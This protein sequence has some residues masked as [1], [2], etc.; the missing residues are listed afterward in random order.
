MVN[1]WARDRANWFYLSF[2]I[3][4]LAIVLLGFSTTY[5]IPMAWRSFSAPPI[6]HLHGAA[7]LAWVTIVIVQA[8][9]VSR[10]RT[11]I[12]RRF[13][14]S[15]L[16]LALLVWVSGIYTSVWA[17][18][19]DLADQGTAATSSLAGSAIGLS[20]YLGLVIAAVM[21]RRRPDWHKR[22]I[23]LATIQLLWPAFFRLRHLMPMIPNP[24]IWLALVLAY[25]P[26][27][28]FALRDRLV[29]GRIHPVW[30]FV[31]PALILEQSIEF[32]MFDRGA[33]RTLGQW[34]YSL[35]S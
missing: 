15:A 12:H 34:I 27:V 26:V 20:L 1:V 11:P 5:I 35:L 33:L 9:L 4:A 31:A 13:G 29:C 7:A 2:G 21:L 24:E 14:L 22:L 8:S 23:L 32:A 17:A 10:S 19:R 18:N 6:V 16:P 28:I 3:F 30:L 25:S